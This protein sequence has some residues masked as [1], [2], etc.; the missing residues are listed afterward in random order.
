MSARK[1]DSRSTGVLG[2]LVVSAMLLVSACG[3][4][5]ASPSPSASANKPAVVIQQPANGALLASGQSVVVS[6]AASDTVGVDR[7]ALLVDGGAVAGTPP[8]APATL[9]PFS[10]NW[11]ATP[12]SH[13]LQVIAY[14]ADGTASDPAVI[15]VTVGATASGVPVASFAT[16][17]PVPLPS[18]PAPQRT[19]K[20]RRTQVPTIVPTESPNTVPTPTPV[21]PTDPPPT[22]PPSMGPTPDANGY[23]PDDSASQ[24]YQIVFAASNPACPAAP[25]AP[26]ISA[27][28]CIT[29]Q[30]SAPSGDT[31]DQ[32]F[33]VPASN[34]TY[35]VRLTSCSDQS[36]ATVVYGFDPAYGSGCGFGYSLTMPA[37]QPAQITV[38]VTFGSVAAQTYNLYQ[39][40]VYQCAFVNC[41][42]Q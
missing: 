8:G 29:E 34:L 41:G 22:T 25:A 2:A 23:A 10:M 30:I 1:G 31:A 14:R 40:T 11:L 13:T 24:P 9:I 28:G 35:M 16:F 36:N 27:V 32:L 18:A 26:P 42:T 3:G 20:P 33:F 17:A 5:P 38:N 12:G 6:G 7:V 19:K 21:T 37:A 39:V 15:Q 4:A